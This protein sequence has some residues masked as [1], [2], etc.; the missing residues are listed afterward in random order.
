MV[1]NCAL[2]LSRCVSVYDLQV[3]SSECDAELGLN[4]MAMAASPRS[5]AFPSLRLLNVFIANV[6][7]VADFLYSPALDNERYSLRST[8]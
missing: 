6:L 4:T 3:S 1:Y 5:H 2:V 7:P 8:R